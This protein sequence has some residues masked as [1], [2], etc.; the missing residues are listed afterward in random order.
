MKRLTLIFLTALAAFASEVHAEDAAPR[1]VAV[2]VVLISDAP[3]AAWQ[4]EFGG[5]SDAVRIVGVEQGESKAFGDAPYYDR[6]A[7]RLGTADRIVVA[8]YSTADSSYLPRGAVRIAT[9]HLMIT[10]HSNEAI[11]ITLVTA[12][13]ADGER[14][15]A[16]ISATPQTGSE[17]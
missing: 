8:D 12:V 3:V 11:D 5:S 7:I 13:D 10:G 16:S 15:E 1:F 14:I 4:F 2:D 9:L 6:E 17:S